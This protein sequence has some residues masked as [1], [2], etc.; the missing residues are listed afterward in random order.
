MTQMME[1]NGFRATVDYDPHIEMVRGEFVGLNAASQ[2]D[3][4]FDS[5]LLQSVQRLNNQKPDR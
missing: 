3:R 2:P 1:V 5:N 4:P